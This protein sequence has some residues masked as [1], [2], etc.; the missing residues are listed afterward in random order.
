[1]NVGFT[2]TQEG[3]TPAQLATFKEIFPK[4]AARFNQGC[5][6]GADEQAT[7]EVA[8]KDI[9]IMGY[10]SYITSKTSNLAKKNSDGLRG[11]A[12]PIDRNGHIVDD[13]DI[14]F[15]CPKDT[16]EELR[17]GT[18]STIRRARKKGIPIVYIWPDGSY[19]DTRQSDL[20]EIPVEPQVWNSL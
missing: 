6:I 12:N 10:P 20:K 14:L 7:L 3:M 9:I 19:T 1:M 16:K 2:G 8:K 13:S 17:S 4:E 5:C 11:V 15:A 18:W